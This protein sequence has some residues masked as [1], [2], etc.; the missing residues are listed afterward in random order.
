MAGNFRHRRA[1]SNT[2][3]KFAGV[4][5]WR[6]PLCNIVQPSL[7]RCATLDGSKGVRHVAAGRE[8]FFQVRDMQGLWHKQGG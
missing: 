8:C 4:C 1:D 6:A 3:R 5:G 2:Y 7:Q